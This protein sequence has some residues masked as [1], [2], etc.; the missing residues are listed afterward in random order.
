MCH[1]AINASVM[2]LY[3]T[4]VGF[5]IYKWYKIRPYY[6]SGEFL[7]TTGTLIWNVIFTLAIGVSVITQAIL[8]IQTSARGNNCLCCHMNKDQNYV[9]IDGQDIATNPASSRVS[10]PS[11]TYFS[12]PYTGGFST[13]IQSI[14]DINIGGEDH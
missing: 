10:P 4:R 13:S 7:D 5:S 3:S 6:D 1:I 12:V 8:C 11:H 14:D 9:A 2:A